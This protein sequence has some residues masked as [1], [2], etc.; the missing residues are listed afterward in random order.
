MAAQTSTQPW[1]RGPLWD[2][3][4]ILNGLWLAPLLFFL[5][6]DLILIAQE[7]LP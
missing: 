2:G 7:A 3:F 6:D 4:W 5:A 1:V